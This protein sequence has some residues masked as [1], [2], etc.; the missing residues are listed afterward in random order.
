VRFAKRQ[1][2]EKSRRDPA[3][4]SPMTTKP[5]GRLRMRKAKHGPIPGA[6]GEILGDGSYLLSS[7]TLMNGDTSP[8][9][10]VEPMRDVEQSLRSQQ[11]LPNP[12]AQAIALQT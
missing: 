5:D 3:V 11:M 12:W 6:G 7:K 1:E 9:A 10:Y 8:A 4:T 2:N